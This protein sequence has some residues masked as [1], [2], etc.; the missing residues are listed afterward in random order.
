MAKRKYKVSLSRIA[1]EIAKAEKALRKLERRVSDKDKKKIK[2]EIKELAKVN[3]S[4]A[5]FCTGKAGK[6]T[7][8]FAARMTG[9]PKS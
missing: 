4:L 9:C 5:G 3:R 1:K 6:M 7:Q 2:L 8:V